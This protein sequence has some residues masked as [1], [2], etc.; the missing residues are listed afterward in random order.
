MLS[1]KLACIRL[2]GLERQNTDKKVN[3]NF[4]KKWNNYAKQ[5]NKVSTCMYYVLCSGLSL[6]T[7]NMPFKEEIK[8]MPIIYICCQ[9]K[10][11][12]W[13][14]LPWTSGIT[15]EIIHANTSTTR[16]S[17]C[18]DATLTD[19]IQVAIS[20]F[21]CSKIKPHTLLSAILDKH[22]KSIS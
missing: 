6:N 15:K 10:I 19:I 13:A 9:T 5:K 22:N 8:T 12:T 14:F 7:K 11:V 18:N 2:T 4:I 20:C 16:S 21:I 1:I 3:T 17:I